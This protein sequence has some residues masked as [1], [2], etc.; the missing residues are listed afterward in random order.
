MGD[1]EL[2]I[3]VEGVMA[4]YDEQS[5]KQA[6]DTLSQ[7]MEALQQSL[8]DTLS[9][10]CLGPTGSGN[11]ADYMAE[12]TDSRLLFAMFVFLKVTLSFLCGEGSYMEIGGTFFSFFSRSRILAFEIEF[13]RS[14]I[15]AAIP[16]TFFCAWYASQKH[17]LANNILGL[18][19]CIQKDDEILVPHNDFIE[20]PQSM[21]GEIFN[22]HLFFYVCFSGN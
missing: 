18:A 4:H 11:V 17:W 9:S 19:F 10:A 22:S 8:V 16:G 6:E 20:G 1:N 15:I 14:Q 2:H 12:P 3:L 21:E 7:E 5:S 13:T